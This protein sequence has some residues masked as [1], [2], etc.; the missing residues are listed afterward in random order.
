VRSPKRWAAGLFLCAAVAA[1]PLL[2][3]AGQHGG[4]HGG[5]AEH[6]PSLTNAPSSHELQSDKAAAEEHAE[7]GEEHGPPKPINWFDFGN[8]E[9]PPFA[10][11]ILNFIVLAAMY[12]HFGKKPIAEGLKNRRAEVAKE[13]EEAQRMKRE[14]E[15]RAK[16]YQSKLE[17]LEEEL[18]MTRQALHDAGE[19]EKARIIKE[20]EEKAARMRKDA[21]FLIE[22]EIKQM[23]QDLWRETVDMA[24]TAAEELLKN[25]VTT[26]DQER[27]AEDYLA[28]LGASEARPAQ[29]GA[30]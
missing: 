5:A 4:D 7:H 27:L 20:A 29:G 24:V 2:V 25:K 18:A 17:R 1:L 28:S 21:E 16:Q 12:Y 19:G 26:A 22:Q 3:W 30:S 23:K 15:A 6:G 13:I 11:A 14:A 10:A 9:Q 8:K